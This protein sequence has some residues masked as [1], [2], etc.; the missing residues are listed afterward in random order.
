MDLARNAA[1]YSSVADMGPRSEI[2]RS[3]TE[4][5]RQTTGEPGSQ[6][7]IRAEQS[8]H[9]PLANNRR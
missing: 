9:S 3:P 6:E 1:S 8:E 2:L 4:G 5:G 7:M